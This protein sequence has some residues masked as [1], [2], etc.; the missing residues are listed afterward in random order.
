[1]IDYDGQ[2]E[3]F[4]SN[5]HMDSVDSWRSL[6]ENLL[7]DRSICLSKMESL[8]MIIEAHAPEK[9]YAALMIFGVSETREERAE[10]R[11]RATARLWA[12]E[13]E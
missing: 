9:Y 6:A 8:V 3:I 1:M 11:N 5:G 10:L 13:N 12:G 4:R 2:L 7:N